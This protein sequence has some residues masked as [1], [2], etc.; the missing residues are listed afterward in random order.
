MTSRINLA[1]F[2]VVM[3]A[4]APSAFAQQSRRLKQIPGATQIGRITSLPS[5]LLASASG[6]ATSAQ[7]QQA[8]DGGSIGRA[9]TAGQIGTRLTGGSPGSTTGNTDLT[10]G[11]IAQR[12]QAGISAAAGQAATI[13][14]AGLPA[15]AITANQVANTGMSTTSQASAR[16]ADTS[17]RISG[18]AG[19]T[20]QA[21]VK[22][23]AAKGAAPVPAA[24]TKPVGGY[25]IPTLSS[26][27]AARAA[28]AAPSPAPK[29]APK[30]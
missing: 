22:A 5:D 7:I 19:T 29:P 23:P 1:V 27:M 18:A 12:T 20:V 30:P 3:V 6:A 10:A 14:N 4:S 16:S 2:L 9:T 8:A 11:A 25:T 26:V 13:T 17:A 24:P 28:A 21:A 15:G